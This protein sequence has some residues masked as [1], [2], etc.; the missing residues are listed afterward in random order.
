VTSAEGSTGFL[1]HASA[2]AGG[3]A[4]NADTTTTGTFT[5][6]VL[7]RNRSRSSQPL[8]FGNLRSS[9]TIAGGLLPC[10]RKSQASAPSLATST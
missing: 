10:I 5:N 9:K 2:P 1:N 4:R 7:F 6:M 3:E 8:T